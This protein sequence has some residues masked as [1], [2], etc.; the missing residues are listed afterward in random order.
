MSYPV[1]VQTDF[2]QRRSRLSTFFRGLTLIPLQIVGFFYLL[3]VYVAVIVAWFALMFTGRWPAGLYN[4]ATRVL[5]WVVRV[6]A[7]S[8]LATD[9]YPPFGLSDAPDYPIQVQIAPPL[10]KYSRVKVFFRGLYEIPVFVISYLLAIMVS[11]V[12]AASWLVIVV[13]GRQP[14]G[15]QNV[16]NFGVSYYAGTMSLML[17]VT[18]TYPPLS[19]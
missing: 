11:I 16:I 7:Y 6:T 5:R 3:G 13:T 4:Y 18:E 19:A 14:Q 10:E 12:A 15:L 9:A 17:L 2:T 8:H 1:E